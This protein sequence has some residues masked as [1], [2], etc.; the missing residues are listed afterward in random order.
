MLTA[1][2]IHNRLWDLYSLI[3]LLTVARGHQNPFGTTGQFSRKFIADER[4]KAR[5]I[6]PEAIEEFR[7]IVYGYMSRVRRGD[8][9]LHFPDRIVRRHQVDPTA[10]EL[11]LIKTIA[12]PIKSLNR[13]AQISILKALASSP[14]ALNAQ[15]K[16]TARNG[17]IPANLSQSVDAIVQRMPKTAKLIGLGQLIEQLKKQDPTRWRLVIFTTLRETQTT[18]QNFL[19]SYGLKVG[20]ING[21]SGERNQTTIAR[22]QSKPPE[23]RIIV[24]TE[25]GAE[26]VNLQVAN[27]LVNFDLPWNPMVVE[28]RIGRIQRLAS[29]YANVVVYNLTLRGTFEDY[30]VG[31]LMEKLQMASHAIGDIESLLQGANDEDAEEK[32]EERLLELVL[33][34]LAGKDKKKSAELE[35]ASIEEAINTL[36]REKETIEDLLGESDDRGYVGPR[37]PTLPLTPRSMPV[38]EFTVSGLRSLGAKVS[39]NPPD[40]YLVEELAGRHYIRFQKSSTANVKSVLYN[41]SSGA[42]QRLVDRITASALH[43]VEDADHD[44]EESNADIIRAW[45]K[46]FGG[47]LKDVKVEEVNRRFEEESSFECARQSHTTATNAS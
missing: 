46:S 11:L 30:I 12:E 13:L 27:V 31:R 2:P 24:S 23:Y 25:A 3:D 29:E 19:E 20:I 5:R 21:D 35:I 33:A 34:A 8:A 37:A 32:F 4:E 6:K 42:F 45:T 43:N 22:F 38:E 17:T 28:Q 36:E 10:S 16:N 26:G 40:L 44:A 41:E 18:I 1:T 14:E 15:L 7:S 47:I 9:K 39:P